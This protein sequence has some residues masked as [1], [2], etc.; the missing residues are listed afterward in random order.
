MTQTVAR[1]FVPLLRPLRGRRRVWPLALHG[2]DFGP[3]GIRG[4]EVAA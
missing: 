2:V 1:L 3:R 4:A